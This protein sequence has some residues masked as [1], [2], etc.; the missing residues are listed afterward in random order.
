MFCRQKRSRRAP[1]EHSNR[2]EPTVNDAALFARLAPALRAE[3]GPSFDTTPSRG[4]FSEDFAFYTEQTPAL[5]FGWGIARDGKGT[6]GVHSTDFT[7]HRAALAEGVRFLATL[8]EIALRQ[9]SAWW[10]RAGERRFGDPVR[11]HIF[12]ASRDPSSFTEPSC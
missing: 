10:P 5:Y 12:S 2:S 8:A 3:W 6:G 7:I 9:R 4:M 11:D 1:F